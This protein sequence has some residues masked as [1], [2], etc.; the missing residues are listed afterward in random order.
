MKGLKVS[1]AAT[2]PCP[3]IK[4]KLAA[5]L[6]KP[7]RVPLRVNLGDFAVPGDV[8]LEKSAF[9][10]AQPVRDDLNLNDDLAV[11]FAPSSAPAWFP[12]FRGVLDVFPGEKPDETIVELT[13]SYEPP[14]G[15]AGKA[16]DAALGHLIAQRSIV[17]FLQ[18]IL[19]ES[20]T[21]AGGV[22][23]C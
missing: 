15:A 10:L 7:R 21:V 9:V 3:E 4:E 12:R 6:R 5:A 16:F 14:F 23:P 19:T 2:G 20:G 22:S 18:Q 8:A 13:G 11:E 1:V 17:S